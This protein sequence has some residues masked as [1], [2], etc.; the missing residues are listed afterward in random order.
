MISIRI[1]NILR[2]KNNS[3]SLRTLNSS[4]L[5]TSRR[6]INIPSYQHE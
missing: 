5:K 6:Q 3:I 4:Q 1:I 2:F